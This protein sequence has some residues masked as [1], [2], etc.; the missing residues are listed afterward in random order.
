MVLV[1]NNE[2]MDLGS[3]V[4]ERAQLKTA[5]HQ[6]QS[7]YSGLK[8]GL[9]AT[10]RACEYQLSQHNLYR[11]QFDFVRARL[12]ES[13]EEADRLKGELAHARD[14]LRDAKHMAQQAKRQRIAANDEAEFYLDA[15]HNIRKCVRDVLDPIPLE[16]IVSVPATTTASASAPARSASPHYNPTY[17][18]RSRSEGSARPGPSKSQQP[19]SPAYTPDSEAYAR[20]YAKYLADTKA[21]LF[22]SDDEGDM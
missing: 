8:S 15:L 19:R 16:P 13:R 18:D 7:D 1:G 21:K 20:D 22:G 5:L 4:A 2:Y 9:D 14:M 10:N 12:D 6:L 17:P 11:E 3:L